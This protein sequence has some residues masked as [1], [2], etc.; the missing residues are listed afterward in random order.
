MKN[1]SKHTKAFTLIELLVVISIIAML[2]SILLPALGRARGQAKSII[3]SSRIRQMLIAA[4]T[5]NNTYNGYYP[6]AQWTEKTDTGYKFLSWDFSSNNGNTE[7]GLLWMGET[8]T[9]IQQCPSFKGNENTPSDQYTGYN[10]NT[11]YIG[12]GKNETVETPA[13]AEQIQRPYR[14]AVFGD[15]E[16]SYGANKYMRS[17]LASQFDKSFSGRY[18]GTQGFRHIGKTNVAWADGH[19]SNLKKCYGEDSQAS[20][21]EKS[22]IAEGTGFLSEDNFFYNIK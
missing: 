17:P 12:R 14:C 20:E 9:E 16:F 11:S 22:R 8:A 3:C 13:K 4:N 15:G 2:I 18:A 10:Y 5:Y 7:P 6:Y 19:I 1:K 21:S